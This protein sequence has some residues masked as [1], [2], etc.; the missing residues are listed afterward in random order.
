MSVPTTGE[1]YSQLM[2]HLRKAEEA[3]AM[4]AHLHNAND[5]RRAAIQ[6]L[7]VSEGF[8]KMQV[9]ITQLAIGKLN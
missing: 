5:H 4:L 7:T 2:E 8:K 6:W 3:A 1:T 9:Q